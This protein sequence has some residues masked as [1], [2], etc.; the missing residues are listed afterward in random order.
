MVEELAF[1]L[2]DVNRCCRVL[3]V[4]RS[5]YYDWRSRPASNRKVE[6]E[7][8]AMKLKQHWEDSRRTYGLPRL[9]EKLKSEGLKVGKNR[10]QKIHTLR[11]WMSFQLVRT[12]SLPNQKTL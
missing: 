1:E 10:I 6:N 12:A 4:S 5:G 7:N 8:L 3:K 2:Q 11:A 9:V